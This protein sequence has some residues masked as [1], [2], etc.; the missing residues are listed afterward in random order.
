MEDNNKNRLL[1]ALLGVTIGIVG[2]VAYHKSVQWLSYICTILC[3]M[4]WLLCMFSEG[5]Q[6]EIYPYLAACLLASYYITGSYTNSLCYGIC[7]Y[8]TTGLFYIGLLRFI[9]HLLFIVVPIVSLAAYFLHY[10]QVFMGTATFC[11]LYFFITHLLGKTPHYAMDVFLLCV[12]FGVGLM[13]NRGAE[14]LY[15]VSIIKGILWGGSAYYIIGILY[16]FFHRHDSPNTPNGTGT[17]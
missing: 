1:L 2:I 5:I 8:Y 14:S 13:V 16:A 12:A 10:E 9:P 15:S 3:I 4:Q 11:T 17:T 7:L 6:K